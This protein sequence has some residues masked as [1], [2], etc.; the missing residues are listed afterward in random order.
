MNGEP[1]R[2]AA[3]TVIAMDAIRKNMFALPAKWHVGGVS[4]CRQALNPR[5][6]YRNRIARPSR[7][8]AE[9]PLSKLLNQPC[10]KTTDHS[11]QQAATVL[12]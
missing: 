1:I 10:V 9:R 2:A 8:H 6:K 11:V 12:D 5:A 4:L 3:D 7:I